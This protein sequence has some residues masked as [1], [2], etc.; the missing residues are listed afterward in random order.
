MPP[1]ETSSSMHIDY[2]D[3][4]VDE[5]DIDPETLGRATWTFLHSMAAMFPLTPSKAESMR[6][7]RFMQ[8]FGHLYPCAPCAYSFRKILSSRPPETSS[9]PVF[10]RWMCQAHNDVNR[11][12][13]KPEFDCSAESIAKRWGACEACKSHSGQL[14]AFKQLAGLKQ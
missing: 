10:A 12:L 5:H 14:D 1:A 2:D 11:E 8:D 9:G 4:D 6:A 7:A 13:G 3:N